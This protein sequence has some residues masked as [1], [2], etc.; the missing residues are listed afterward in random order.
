MYAIQNIKTGKF[1]YGTDRRYHPYRQRTSWNCLIAFE[2]LAYA[3]HSFNSRMCGK[4][5][6]IVEVSQ[7]VIKREVPFD[8]DGKYEIQPKDYDECEEEGED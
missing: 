7:I 8:K 2:S 4:D 5:Y 3:K 1:V 6:R